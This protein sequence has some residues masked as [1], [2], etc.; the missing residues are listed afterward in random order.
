MVRSGTEPVDWMQCHPISNPQQA[1][2]TPSRVIPE[3]VTRKAGSAASRSRPAARRRKLLPMVP[4]SAS[5]A[6]QVTST[7]GNALNRQPRWHRNSL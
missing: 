3:A 5:P 6:T 7:A 4:S 2:P 1:D